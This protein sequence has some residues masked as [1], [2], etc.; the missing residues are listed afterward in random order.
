MREGDEARGVLLGADELGR[1]G[2]A[3]G[4]DV[5]RERE[6]LRGLLLD[7]EAGTVRA[8]ETSPTKGGGVELG[9]GHASK[10][11]ARPVT[12]RARGGIRRRAPTTRRRDR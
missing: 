3:A 6:R 12:S 5:D 9:S 1:D 7:V 8:G 10:G 2:E 11:C 4:V